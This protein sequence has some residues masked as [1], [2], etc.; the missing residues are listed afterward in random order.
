MHRK[1]RIGNLQRGAGKQ[2]AVGA[3]ECLQ[4]F[5]EATVEVLDSMTLGF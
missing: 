4:I 3:F 1:G 5:D 2:K